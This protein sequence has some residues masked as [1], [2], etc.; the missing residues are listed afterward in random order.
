MQVMIHC[1]QS[2]PS[3]CYLGN[4]KLTF[5]HDPLDCL[6][7]LS[8]HSNHL[9]AQQLAIYHWQLGILSFRIFV[10]FGPKIPY[11]IS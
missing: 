2:Q 7:D 8:L 3:I 1:L 6:D 4:I 9:I 10:K 5:I 11:D